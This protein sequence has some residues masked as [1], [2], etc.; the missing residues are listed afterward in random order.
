MCDFQSL[1]LMV[2][3]H[4]F[5]IQVI[6]ICHFLIYSN[7]LLYFHILYHLASPSFSFFLNNTIWNRNQSPKHQCQ[8][9]FFLR[10]KADLWK[11]CTLLDHM[12]KARQVT[13]GV[14]GEISWLNNY[15]YFL[16]TPHPCSF[17]LKSPF[18]LL[19]LLPVHKVIAL[20]FWFNTVIKYL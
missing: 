8:N 7:F 9:H 19:H 18:R 1:F 5:L 11:P 15:F 20:A 6:L 4:I 10:F 2:G 12:I 13:Q 3:C 16:K 14:S 17:T